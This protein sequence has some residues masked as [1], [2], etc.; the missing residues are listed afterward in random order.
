M[1]S[2]NNKDRTRNV[3]FNIDEFNKSLHPDEQDETTEG[4]FKQARTGSVYVQ[5]KDLNEKQI[6]GN[7]KT[8]IGTL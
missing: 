3:Q 8:K 7:W 5:Y 6:E 2:N 1:L 4:V